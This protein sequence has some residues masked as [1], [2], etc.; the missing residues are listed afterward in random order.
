M[1]LKCRHC[2]ASLGLEDLVCPHCGMPN[3]EAK[4]HA[5]EMRR[6]SIDYA[7]TKESVTR[8]AKRTGRIAAHAIILVLVLIAD[9]IVFFLAGNSYSLRREMEVRKAGRNHAKYTDTMSG[10][11]DNNDYLG[12]YAFCK[13]NNINGYDSP[14]EIYGQSISMCR[15][16][17]YI[18]SDIAQM[19][20]PADYYNDV[21]EYSAKNFYE[22]LDRFYKISTPE[23][24]KENSYKT[25]DTVSLKTAEGLRKQIN[26]LLKA[27]LHLEEEEVEALPSLSLSK[28]N[29]ILEE[30]ILKQFGN[31]TEKET[32]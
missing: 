9:M 25:D 31:N 23:Y 12:F 3:E 6:Y 1:Q 21:T 10:Y 20:F 2:G 4:K 27:Y 29:L 26:A 18:Y 16:Y 28:R 19:I 24:I 14:Y 11:L 15:E 30:H 17:R 22:S 32:K 13:A 7:E 8:S 5:E